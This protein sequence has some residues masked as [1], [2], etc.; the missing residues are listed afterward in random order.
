MRSISIY[1]EGGG[2]SAAQRKELRQGFDKLF[3]PQKQKAR[4]ERVSL[5]FVLCGSRNDTFRAFA[6]TRR[7]R[8]A[9]ET[10]VLLVDSEEAFPG[11]ASPTSDAR[12]RHLIDRDGWNLDGVP[13]EQVHLMVPCMEAWIIADPDALAR[14]YGNG[15]R[16]DRLP[17]RQ[18]LEAEPKVR[19]HDALKEA[20]RNTSKG[21]YG[22]IRHARDLLPQLHHAVVAV[23]CPHFS[24]FTVWLDAQIAAD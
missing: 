4:R 5:K 7:N 1:V 6:N 9:D 13:G 15:F 14:H 20:T 3:D 11:S 18:N 23:R 24:M 10:V 8:G 17:P 16:P 12:R 19:I 21:E 2:N 22:K